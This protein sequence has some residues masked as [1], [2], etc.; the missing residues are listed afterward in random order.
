MIIEVIKVIEVTLVVLE[1]DG[2][3]E[4][5]AESSWC[6]KSS[7]QEMTAGCRRTSN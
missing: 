5:L 6:K 2:E 7:R 3:L 1:Q 4:W